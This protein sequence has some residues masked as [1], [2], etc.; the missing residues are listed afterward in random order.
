MRA[1]LVVFLLPIIAYAQEPTIDSFTFEWHLKEAGRCRLSV[2]KTESRVCVRIWDSYR[3]L[4]LAPR[5]A[6]E[7]AKAFAQADQ[8]FKKLNGRDASE[9]IIVGEYS[10]TMSNKDASFYVFTHKIKGFNASSVML[11]R[12]E[13]REFA[14]LLSQSSALCERANKAVKP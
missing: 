13:A 14:P 4:D 8:Y 3:S 6:E 2:V 9:S 5:D 11:T 1:F 7:V 12:Q 10:V